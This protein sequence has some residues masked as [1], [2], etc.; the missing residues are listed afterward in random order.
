MARTVF[1]TSNTDIFK[2][3]ADQETFYGNGGTDLVTYEN[4]NVRSFDLGVTADLTTGRGYTGFASQDRYVSIENLTGTNGRDSLGGDY[5][6][7]SLTGLGG[8]D[9]FTPRY[10]ADTV[11]GG[12]GEDTVSYHSSLSGVRVYLDSG[13]GYGGEAEGDRLIN[14]EHVEGSSHNDSLYGDINDNHLKGDRGDDYLSGNGGNDFLDGGEG[15]DWLF[16]G[17]GRDEL[18][19]GARDD[20]LS[21]GSGADDLEGGFGNDRLVMMNDEAGATEIVRGDVYPGDNFADTFILEPT[22]SGVEAGRIFIGD[23]DDADTLDL[24]RIP[25]LTSYDQLDVTPQ[26]GRVIIQFEDTVNLYVYLARGAEFD[27]GDVIV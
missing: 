27:A 10:G 16:G 9:Y 13:R 1:G 18:R 25:G 2:A 24:S 8:D 11:D 6:G 3:T 23:F 5:R 20:Y 15:F 4:Q 19:G 7:N 12:T 21:G 14:I 26:S 17:S 22:R